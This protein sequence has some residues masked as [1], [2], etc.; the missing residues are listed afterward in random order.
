MQ[1]QFYEIHRSRLVH[2]P[3][4]ANIGC[5]IAHYKVGAVSA[6]GPQ[7][8]LENLVIVNIAL[9]ELNAWQ[10][11]HRQQVDGDDPNPPFELICD[12][13]TPAAWCRAEIHA[14]YVGSQ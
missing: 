3:C 8:F 13:L 12:I 4:S 2:S 5:D 6:Y 9:N 10:S 11:I 7:Q 1:C 14:N